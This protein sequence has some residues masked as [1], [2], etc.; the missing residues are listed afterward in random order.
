MTR[1]PPG[2]KSKYPGSGFVQFRKDPMGFL[3]RLAREFG[4]VVHWRIV[5]Q[6]TFLIN[7][8]DLIRDVLVTDARK[9]CKEMK[10]SRTLLCEG[11]TVSDGE[12]HRRQRRAIQPT[13]RHERIPVFAEVMVRYAERARTR[14]R[15]DAT[16]DL[17]EEME[18]ISLA[19]IGETMFGANLEPHAATIQSAMDGAIGSP[20]NM[21]LPLARAVEKLPLPAAHRAKAGRAK[22][23][24]IVEQLIR[25]RRSA[26][27]R[28]E[29]LL[30]ILLRAQNEGSNGARMTDEQIHDE[31]MNLLI[32]GY[33]TVSNALA[34][35]W[36]L[37]S[38]HPEVEAQL[39][40]EIDRV[41]ANRLPTF[42]DIAALQCTENVIRESLRL[43]PPLWMVWRR[44][45]EDYPLDGYVAP[46]G[47][48]IIMSQ[49][50]M[51]RDERYFAEPLRFNPERWT[52]EFS[53]RL[54]KFAYF[55]FGGGP[56]Q[57]VG[58]R[59]GSMEAVLILAT[60]AQKWSL[61]LV[62]GRAVVPNPLLTLR[63]KYGLQMIAHRRNR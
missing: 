11:L 43:Y 42:A 20:P 45:I 38:E 27:D 18:G 57:C 15:D 32:A 62:P 50:V 22:I 28:G 19:V 46:A 39:H 5:G 54:P 35:T 2:P 37:L 56:R 58:D 53:E 24:G 61:R 21:L 12:L 59:F 41:L 36:Y 26:G 14:W 34:W 23:H 47:S 6:H 44:A 30:S 17:K 13:F 52:K 49:H 33:E 8:P 48:I 55:P 63:P 29:D 31:M 9:F 10:A 40:E 51:H 60:V 7:R 3:E 4:D 16:L 25:D 1:F